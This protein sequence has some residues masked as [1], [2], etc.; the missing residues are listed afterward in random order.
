VRTLAVPYHLDEHLPDL[1]LPLA[2]ADVITTDLT[3]SDPWTRMAVLYRRLASVVAGLV[4]DDVVPVVLSGDC[5][6]SL[7]TVAGLQ[8]AGLDPGIVWLDAHGDLHTPA[9]TSSGYLGGMPLRLLA[10]AYPELISASLG[11]RAVPEDRVLLVGARDLDRPEVSHLA[12]AAIRT[13]DVAALDPTA[14]DRA[15]LPGGPLYVHVDADVIDATEIPGLRYPVT[16]GPGR[17]VVAAALRALLG[18][19]R[20]AA[21]GLACTWHPGHGAAAAIAPVAAALA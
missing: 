6:T 1:D 11:L 10:G 21:V 12:A 14:S 13:C 2:A 4:S 17:A 15:A 5:T 9:T 7:G 20:V 16:G 19:G 8:R 18:T 3:A